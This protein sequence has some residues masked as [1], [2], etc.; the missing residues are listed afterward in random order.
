MLLALL[1]GML[2]L[3]CMCSMTKEV[4][5]DGIGGVEGMTMMARRSRGRG[6]YPWAPSW[7]V[8]MVEAERKNS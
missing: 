3:Q 7:Q 4:I 5:G 8:D 1:P 2:C 6:P